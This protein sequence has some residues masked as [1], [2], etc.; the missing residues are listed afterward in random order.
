M[1]TPKLVTTTD[2]SNWRVS[3]LN[4]K[5]ISSVVKNKRPGDFFVFGLCFLSKR[6][7]FLVRGDLQTLTVPFDFFE[8]NN[9][10]KPDFTKF[11]LDKEG[12]SLIM[13]EYEVASFTVLKR[14][15]PEVKAYAK[16]ILRKKKK[17]KA[18]K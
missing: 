10:C 5:K 7:V 4:I 1:D 9:V 3:L 8:P 13:G 6:E 18:E 14:L 2:N 17:V 15:D 16:S 12:M 11:R